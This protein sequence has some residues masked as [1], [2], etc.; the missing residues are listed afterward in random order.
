MLIKKVLVNEPTCFTRTPYPKKMC[1]LF[2]NGVFTSLGKDHAMQRKNL[3]PY[4]STVNVQEYLPIFV[5]KAK[6]LAEVRNIHV[7][8]KHY[9]SI[10]LLLHFVML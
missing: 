7:S 3:N 4:F 8:L 1:P 2:G 5:K 10:V 6:E 9:L